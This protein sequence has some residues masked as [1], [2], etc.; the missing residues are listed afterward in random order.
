MWENVRRLHANTMPFC[1]RDLSIH[2][3]WYLQEGS[4]TNPPQIPRDDCMYFSRWRLV[5]DACCR[6]CTEQH[7]PRVTHHGHT[8][9]SVTTVGEEINIIMGISSNQWAMWAKEIRMDLKKM[10]QWLLRT[11]DVMPPFMLIY[12]CLESP[13]LHSLAP[14]EMRKR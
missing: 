10:R 2:E 4:G 5:Q 14:N 8:L 3:F 11:E 12:L 1:K 7:L 9:L 6:L 13:H